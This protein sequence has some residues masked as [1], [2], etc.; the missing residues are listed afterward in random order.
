V[1]LVRGDEHD[2]RRALERAEV[3]RRLEPIPGILMSSS[4]TSAA[5]AGTSSIA[6]TPWRASPTTRVGTSAAMSPSSSFS[7]S[8]AGASSS[9]MKTL[10]VMPS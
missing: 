6:S 5:L 7:R 8:R 2:A 10:R 3:A 1:A 9:T 4:T